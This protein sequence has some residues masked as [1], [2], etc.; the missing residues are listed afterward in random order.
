MARDDAVLVVDQSES[1][2]VHTR[3]HV[4][5][6]GLGGID[7]VQVSVVALLMMGVI[8]LDQIYM[9]KV[10]ARI[11]SDAELRVKRFH[12]KGSFR[13]NQS[14]SPSANAFFVDLYPPSCFPNDTSSH[15]S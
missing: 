2:L 4:E 15:Q 11:A 1:G 3:F 12:Y 6:T 9:V 13:N 14:M 8:R 5:G 7:P 10:A